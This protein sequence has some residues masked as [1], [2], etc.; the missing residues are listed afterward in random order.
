MDYD[1]ALAAEEIV[2]SIN[3]KTKKLL[4]NAGDPKK[5]KDTKIITKWF[6]IYGAP[7]DCAD[8]DASR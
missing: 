3:L 2:G 4:E 6:N 8:N 1:G 5:N 7:I